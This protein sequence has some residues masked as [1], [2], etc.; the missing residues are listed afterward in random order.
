MKCMK[1]KLFIHLSFV[2]LL[3]GTNPK[4]SVSKAFGS[5]EL[6]YNQTARSSR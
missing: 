5:A 6:C 1:L 4:Q 3:E 2:L